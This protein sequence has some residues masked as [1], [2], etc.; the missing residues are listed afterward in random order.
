M[1]VLV[2]KLLSTLTV[3]SALVMV[4]GIAALP[5]HAG[6]SGEDIP[7]VVPFKDP[8]GPDTWLSHTVIRSVPIA[9]ET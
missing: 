1:N 9:S 6:P 2:L 5:I 3:L 7:F 4:P 8:P